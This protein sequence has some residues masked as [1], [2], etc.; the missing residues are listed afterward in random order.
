[1]LASLLVVAA[2]PEAKGISVGGTVP[3]WA[4]FAVLTAL[5]I[6]SFVFGLMNPETTPAFAQG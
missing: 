1:M 4:P 2:P 5:A 6:A 3:S